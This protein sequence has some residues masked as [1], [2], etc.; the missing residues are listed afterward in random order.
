MKTIFIALTISMI[1]LIGCGESSE[2]VSSNNPFLSGTTGFRIDF[3]PGAPPETVFDGGNFDFDLEVKIENAGEHDVSAQDVIVRIDGISPIEF[4]KT[5]SDFTMRGISEDLRGAEKDAATNNRIEGDVSYATFQNLN[6]QGNVV[7]SSLTRPVVASVCYEYGTK[8]VSSLCIL[9]DIT[10]DDSEVCT[11]NEGKT[12]HSSGAPV[13]VTS[14]LQRPAGVDRVEFQFT[15]E[16]QA[17]ASNIFKQ[18]T[19]C[20]SERS[21]KDVVF[22]EVESGLSGLSCTGLQGGSQTS[23]TITLR[24]RSFT[25]RCIQPID[26]ENDFETTVEINLGYAVEESTRTTIRIE[27]SN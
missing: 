17:S 23:G 12:V 20:S 14:F 3:A 25:I 7:G 10:N 22:V 19:E 2:G 15:V 4:G 27:G 16:N 1:F 11:V 8:A 6:Y 21:D 13:K 5:S 18:D 9:D 26:S 24:D